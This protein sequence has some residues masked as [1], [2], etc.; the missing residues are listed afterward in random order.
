MKIISIDND[1]FHTLAYRTA[2]R[3]SVV[4]KNNLP[5]Y[6]AKVDS[7]PH[8]IN[9]IV[10]T[11]DLQGRES[12][13]KTNRLLG[14]AVTEELTLL[15]KQGKIPS[16][17]LAIL[18]GDLYEYPECHKLG[19]SGDVTSV[20]QAFASQFEQVVGVMGNHDLV[21][22]SAIPQNVHILDGDSTDFAGLCLAGVGGVVGDEKRTERKSEANFLKALEK[23]ESSNP[24]ITILH[25]GPD[26][27]VN[28]QLGEP[29]IR[30]FIECT[31]P[32]LFVF[33]HC[34]WK[35]PL[36]NIGE[37]QALNVDSK[38]FVLEC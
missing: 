10:V 5:F 6:K 21:D 1:P 37:S 7:L 31:N 8:G 16:T 33:G 11:S 15:K 24:I 30:E 12:S 32:G 13:K 18:A 28:D 17:N 2:G 25:Q 23:T 20:W 29:F 35:E 22:R 9:S 38:V 14:E 34:Y 19:G 26:D 36:I 27:P 3:K 4:R